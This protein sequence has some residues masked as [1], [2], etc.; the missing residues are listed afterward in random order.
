MILVERALSSLLHLVGVHEWNKG[1]FV[2]IFHQTVGPYNF[3]ED[4]VKTVFMC[5]HLRCDHDNNL[6]Q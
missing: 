2:D 1:K 6:S 4:Y 5:R 3:K